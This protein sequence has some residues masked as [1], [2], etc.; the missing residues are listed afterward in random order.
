V[1]SIRILKGRGK[2]ILRIFLSVLFLNLWVNAVLLTPRL[3]AADLPDDIAKFSQ[4]NPD[5]NKY[6]FVKT[7]LSSLGYLKLNGERTADTLDV[8]IK[9]MDEKL[10]GQDMIKNIEQ[11]N[12]HLRVARNLLKKHALSNNK[13]IIKVV[14]LFV[15]MCDEQIKHNVV[16]QKLYLDLYDAKKKGR[17]LSFDREKFVQELK[18]LVYQKKESSRK[19]LE[20]SLLVSKIL[21]SSKPDEY[22]EF[23]TLGITSQ[24]RAKLLKKIEE[25][26]GK[27]YAGKLRG[28]QTFLEGS[29][30]SIREVLEDESWELLDGQS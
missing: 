27:G 25:F 30:S 8:S 19:L 18:T 13:M 5:G 17:W 20:A 23:I 14:D 15:L 7:F 11:D 1:E 16:E 26:E 9:D 22:G 6:E 10:L 12:A 4:F 29:I 21:V 3:L 2:M 28:G 24:E